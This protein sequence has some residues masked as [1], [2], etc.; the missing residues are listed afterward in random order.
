M[1]DPSDREAVAAAM[2]RINRA[3]LDRRPGDLPGLF[4]PDVTMVFPGFAG[5]ATGR[6]ALVAGF[7]DFCD[8][9][10]VHE[11]RE[12]DLQVDTVGDVGAVSFVYEMVYERNATRYRAIGR[13]LWVFARQAGDWLAVWRTMLDVSEQPV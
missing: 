12:S 11:Y 9:A 13:D 1:P 5:R 3:W 4:H 10:I 2:Q 7:H 6:D 8:Q